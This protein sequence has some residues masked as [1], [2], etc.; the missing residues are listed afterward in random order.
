MCWLLTNQV[1]LLCVCLFE[2]EWNDLVA[3]GMV[4]VH[5]YTGENDVKE[6]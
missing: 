2:Q 5:I 3:D 4:S 6:E 1:I